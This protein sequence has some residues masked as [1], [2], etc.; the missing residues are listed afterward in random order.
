[1]SAMIREPV[2]A[3]HFYPEKKETL[4]RNLTGLCAAGAA[5]EDAIGAV[6]PHAGYLYSGPVAAK[7]IGSLAP[8][9]VYIIIGPNH[10]GRGRPFGVSAASGWKTPLGEAKVHTELAQEIVGNSAYVR[11][12]ER[13]HEGEHSVEVQLPFLQFLQGTFRFVPIAAADAPL[14]MYR[15]IGGEIARAVKTLGLRDD[16]TIIASS[17]MTHYE[18]GASA[19]KKDEAAIGAILRL[20]EQALIERIARYDISMCGYAPAAIM[21]TA[22]KELGAKKARLV[23][24]AT[25]ADATGDDSSVV[26]YAGIIVT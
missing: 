14:D 22:A 9:G 11:Y 16:I 19:R 4:L 23:S 18:S 13:C 8:K 20:D 24:Y 12:D 21:L 2:V 6:S 1:M 3:G 15:S 7:I 5:K 10:T 26:G 17:D 25:S